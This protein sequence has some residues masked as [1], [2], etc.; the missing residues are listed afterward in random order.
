MK[1]GTLPGF[2]QACEVHLNIISYFTLI[3]SIGLLIDFNMHILVRYYESPCKTRHEKVKD[4]LQTMGSSVLIGGISTFLGVVPLLFSTSSFMKNLFYGFWG[5]VVI[6]CGHGLIVLPVVLSY[7]GP[8]GTYAVQANMSKCSARNIEERNYLTIQPTS[9][10]SARAHPQSEFEDV[11]SD[12]SLQKQPTTNNNGLGPGDQE[13]S[14]L[15]PASPSFQ[16]D[17]PLGGKSSQAD[18]RQNFNL[19]LDSDDSMDV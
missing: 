6:G 7:I 12:V 14:P 8:E 4:S 16:N 2:L 10:S 11:I 18:Q 13:A 17:Q 19:S 5:M 3:I 15:V 9:D 1:F